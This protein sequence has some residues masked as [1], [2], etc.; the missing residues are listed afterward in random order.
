[1]EIV[2]TIPQLRSQVQAWQRQ[3]L[4]TGF[5]P[6]MGNLHAGHIHL[7]EAARSKADRVIASIFVNPIQFCVGEDYASYPHTPDQDVAKLAAAGLDLLFMPAVEDIYPPTDYPATFVEV[8]GLSG[9]LCGHFRPGHFR[10]VTTVVC[11]LFNLLQPDYAFFGEK[12][13]QQLVVIRRMVADLNLPV[14]I[15]GVATVRDDDGLALSSRN[16]YLTAT[17]RALAPRLYQTLK[18]LAAALQNGSTHYADLEQQ[19]T[20]QLKQLGFVPD[21]LS[22]RRADD[23]AQP[24]PNDADLVILLAAR[25]GKTR[26]IDNLRL[27]DLR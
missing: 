7:V 6:T 21:Y 22:I 13:Y 18:E 24:N 3:G 26:L 11:K 20:E 5:V 23:L 15:Q 12:D 14:A 17:E 27:T 25:L 16:S 9:E 1:M 8:P 19:Y 10:G 2:R 4:T